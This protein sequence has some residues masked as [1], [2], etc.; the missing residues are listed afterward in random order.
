MRD[1][2]GVKYLTA[3]QLIALLSELPRDTMV[4]PNVVGN[5]QLRSPQGRY[6]G[7]IDFLFGETEMLEADDE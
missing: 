7:F 4:M 6:I 5:L 3:E 1:E 2:A